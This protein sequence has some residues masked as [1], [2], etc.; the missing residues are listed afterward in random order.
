M[1]KKAVGETKGILVYPHLGDDDTLW[2]TI[3]PPQDIRWSKGD[4]FIDKTSDLLDNLIWLSSR[5]AQKRPRKNPP[6][7]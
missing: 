2:W 5:A 4:L 7:K 6:K 1:P 3:T